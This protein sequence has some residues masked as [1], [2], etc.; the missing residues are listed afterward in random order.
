LKKVTEQEKMVRLKRK[1]QIEKC[2]SSGAF[3]AAATLCR[4][5]PAD[6]PF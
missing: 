3:E 1:N 5:P 2:F 4:S 6:V